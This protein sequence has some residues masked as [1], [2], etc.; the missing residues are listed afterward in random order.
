MNEV[1]R[2]VKEIGDDEIEYALQF[3]LLLAHRLAGDLH[4][5]EAIARASLERPRPTERYGERYLAGVPPVAMTI[6]NLGCVLIH[7]GRL[8]EAEA[9]I[10]RGLGLSFDARYLLG[11][12]VARSHLVDLALL[13]GDERGVL[14]TARLVLQEADSAAMA[15]LYVIT[16]LVAVARAHLVRREFPEA[17][18]AFQRAIQLAREQD[19]DL[20]VETSYLADLAKAR[21]GGGD[22]NGALQTAEETLTLARSRGTLLAELDAEIVR[23]RALLAIGECAAVERAEESLGVAKALI[24]K[25]G[26]ESRSPLIHVARAE[27]AR[28][29][30]DREARASELRAAHRLFLEIGA[31]IRAEQVAEELAG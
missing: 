16:A 7:R 18:T 26:A 11:I 5:A 30:D 24:E 1:A 15:P 27:L 23:A 19:A 9:Y 21:L 3:E 29:L 14:E 12:V 25:T 2:L 13:R 22:A 8:E 6:V 10:Q 28:A 20:D 4:G 31:P 17:I